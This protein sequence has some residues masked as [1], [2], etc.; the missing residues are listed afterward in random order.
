MKKILIFCCIVGFLVSSLPSF[1]AFG[2]N[3][4]IEI[5]INH[6]LSFKLPRNWVILSDNKTITLNSIIESVLPISSKVQ[7][8]ANLKN[9]RGK[10]LTTVQ[11]YR[12]QSDVLQK[13][14][15][16]ISKEDLNNYDQAMR[17]QMQKELSQVGGS[18]RKWLGTRKQ[19]IGSLVA[20][21]SEYSRP[22]NIKPFGHFRVKVLRFYSGINSFSF[23]ISYHEETSIPLRILVDKII[24]TLRCSPCIR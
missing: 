1:S 12:W 22:S 6:N 11:I 17:E 8:Q 13:N 19:Y 5:E 10:P 2:S 14:I 18:I 24:S 15:H 9:D 23:V 16:N 4:F 20:L 21:V 3:T 7:F